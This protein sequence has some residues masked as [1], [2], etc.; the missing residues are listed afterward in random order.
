MSTD[1]HAA[2]DMWL[3]NQ[4]DY[5]A[6]NYWPQAKKESKRVTG[7]KIQD[8]YSKMYEKENA[9]KSKVSSEKVVKQGPST[10]T[11]AK[12]DAKAS[13]G[14]LKA[15][16]VAEKA[17]ETADAAVGEAVPEAEDVKMESPPATRREEVAA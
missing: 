15:E 4:R 17:Y 14:D 13:N 11:P 5:V 7:V 9:G 2:D 10:G 6:D 8:L 1:A 12:S 16:P 3:T